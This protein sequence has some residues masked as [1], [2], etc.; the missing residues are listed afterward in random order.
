MVMVM[1]HMMMKSMMIHEMITMKFARMTL[2]RNQNIC[3]MK[4]IMF[5]LWM[6]MMAL[7]VCGEQF[8]YFY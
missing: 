3:V 8:Q 4:M 7:I 6:R 2:C 5:V 1:M